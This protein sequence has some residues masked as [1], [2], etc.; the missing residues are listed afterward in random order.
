MLAKTA[1]EVP[2]GKSMAPKDISDSR[3]D[4]A[5]SVFG[6]AASKQRKVEIIGI[7]IEKK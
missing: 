3:K 5:N 1:A 2:F 7:R 4:I 6:I